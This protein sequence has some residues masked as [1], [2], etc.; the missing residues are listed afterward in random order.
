MIAPKC[1]L[2]ALDHTFDKN[3]YHI[4]NKEKTIVIKDNFWIAY[5]YVEYYS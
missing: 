4:G 3:Y 5:R 2:F 1:A